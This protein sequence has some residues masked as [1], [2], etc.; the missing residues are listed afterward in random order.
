MGWVSGEKGICKWVGDP[1][2]QCASPT[3]TQAPNNASG[4]ISC[5]I[6]CKTLNHTAHQSANVGDRK[7]PQTNYCDAADTSPPRAP[8]NPTAWSGRL[9]FRSPSTFFLLTT[10]GI[11]RCFPSAL[12]TAHARDDNKPC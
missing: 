5:F 3:P 9:T 2:L 10:L 11:P 12:P 6:S 1:P 7:F 8:S 4:E